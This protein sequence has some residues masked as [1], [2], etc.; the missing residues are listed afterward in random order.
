MIPLAY[1]HVSFFAKP[2]FA[3]GKAELG[4]P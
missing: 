2:M 3:S 1:V 4:N